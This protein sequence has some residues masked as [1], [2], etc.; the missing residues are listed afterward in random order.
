M[1][2][3]DPGS[4]VLLNRHVL[5]LHSKYLCLRTGC[6][7]ACFQL[8]H[9]GGRDRQISAFKAS[10]VYRVG[11]RMVRLQKNPV[12]KTSQPNKQ[13]YIFPFIPID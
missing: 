12:S 5:R 7:G 9:L 11:F 2:K 4:V 3:G 13:E 10:L 6:G 8:Q 1:L